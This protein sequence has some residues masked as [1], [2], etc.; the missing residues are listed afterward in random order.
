VIKVIILIEEYTFDGGAR[1]GARYGEASRASGAGL[2]NG[3]EALPFG[4]Q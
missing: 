3:S 4:C 1:R 2:R